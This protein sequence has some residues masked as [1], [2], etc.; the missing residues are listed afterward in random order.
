MEIKEVMKGPSIGVAAVCLIAGVLIG[1]SFDGGRDWKRGDDGASC[2]AGCADGACEGCQ[3]SG[4]PMK[5]MGGMMGMH[6]MPDG[7]MMMND[8]G[9]VDMGAMM[10]DMTAR[11]EGKKGDA[12]DKV[13]L[14][15]MIVHHQGAVDMAELLAKGSARPE[16]QKF[17]A[18]II[19]VQQA[20]IDQMKAWEKSWFGN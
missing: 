4:C 20:E 10:M 19:R 12:L 15:D 16:M 14:E 17:A 6:Q 2:G 7:S 18:D 1:S 8:G 13:F 11:L 5:K 3:D 9:S